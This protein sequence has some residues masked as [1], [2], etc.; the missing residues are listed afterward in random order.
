MVV[1]APSP[2][3]VILGRPGMRQLGA[4][5][6]TIHSLIK[7]PIPSGIAIVRGDGPCQDECLQVSQKRGRAVEKLP[8]SSQQEIQGGREGI[9][10]NPLHLDQQEAIGTKLST[11][12]KE[13][14]KKFLCANQDVFAWSPSDMTG[15]PRDLSE[16]KLNIHPRTFPIQQKKRVLAKERS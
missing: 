16:H 6:S 4:I 3:N 8:V 1:R 15:I 9:V 11:T 12:L 13:E 7:F 2:Y 14:L 10:I 5:A